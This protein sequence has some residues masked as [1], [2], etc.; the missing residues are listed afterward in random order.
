M[1][2]QKNTKKEFYDIV[3]VLPTLNEEAG[4][5]Q[6]LNSIKQT[7][8][9]KFLFVTYFEDNLDEQDRLSK[10]DVSSWDSDRFSSRK[11]LPGR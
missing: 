8:D 1:L 11:I 5:E 4:I 10:I 3:I 7:F 9:S 6:T 2:E